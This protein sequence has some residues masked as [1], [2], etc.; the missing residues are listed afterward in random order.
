MF[1]LKGSF[2]MD[3]CLKKSKILLLLSILLFLTITVSAGLIVNASTNSTVSKVKYFSNQDLFD[4]LKKHGYN[5][6]D[7]F[8][9]QEIKKYK[10]GD[11]LR[12]GKTQYVETS[13]STSTLY[14]SSAYTK[15]IAALG[16]AASTVIGGLI[17]GGVGAFLGSIASSN[18]NTDK[19][20]YINFKA[21]QDA[22]GQYVLVAQKWGYQ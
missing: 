10:A 22:T 12:A 1:I 7:I 19:G 8:T 9:K 4:E 21:Q 3:I 17:G 13:D 5:I 14:L 11:Q 18:I 2:N 15:M 6:N 16:S 20:I